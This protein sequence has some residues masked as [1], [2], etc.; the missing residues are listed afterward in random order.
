MSCKPW[1]WFTHTFELSAFWVPWNRG[2]YEA[3]SREGSCL[4]PLPLSGR[5]RFESAPVREHYSFLHLMK[6]SKK[7]GQ[8]GLHESSFQKEAL[9]LHIVGVEPE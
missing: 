4:R 5:V 7:C 2:R 6:E 8:V 1:G 3:L 9:Q